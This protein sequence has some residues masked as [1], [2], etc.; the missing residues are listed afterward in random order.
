MEQKE[1]LKNIR[2]Y[3]SIYYLSHSKRKLRQKVPTFRRL[4]F[5]DPMGFR[6]RNL[7]GI[8][9]WTMQAKRNLKA[10]GHNLTSLRLIY[11]YI[12]IPY[13]YIYHISY[14]Y[15]M[16]SAALQKAKQFCLGSV[17]ESWSLKMSIAHLKIHN[18]SMKLAAGRLEIIPLFSGN[19]SIFSSD[20]P[21]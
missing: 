3:I 13:I 6:V 7:G 16:Y 4:W 17:H 19:A 2:I 12:N 1:H 8:H 9:S 20:F 5:G 14:I 15:M 11:I 21:T 10:V 18:P